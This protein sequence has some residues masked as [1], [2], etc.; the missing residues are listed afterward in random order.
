[1]YRRFARSPSNGMTVL[2]FLDFLKASQTELDEDGARNHYFEC[3]KYPEDED[4]AAEVAS[5]TAT[6]G[7]FASAVVRISNA[8]TM[9]EFGESEKGLHEQLVDWLQKFGANVG[10]KKPD[11]EQNTLTY[12]SS[13]RDP[14]FFDPPTEF[15][16]T[17]PKV[18]LLLA[19]GEQEGKVVIELNATASPKCA[20]NF[21]CL[22]TGE[23]GN[24]ELT[25]LP[26][27]LKGNEF[28]RLVK[29]MCLQGG[30]IEGGD[31]YGGESVY[32]GEF[33]DEPFTISHNAAGIVSMGNSGPNTNT[34]QF[35]ITLGACPH[36]DQENNAFGNV[37]E[38]MEYVTQIGELECDEDDKP[39][40]SVLIKDCGVY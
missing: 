7:Q 38:G 6:V 35:F 33:E 1:M 13:K 3:T 20:W 34:S 19:W 15:V 30:D 2:E 23:K 31:G 24:G 17:S 9:Q 21:Q 12:Q 10:E 27:T 39:V 22:C 25:N 8:Y 18:F 40:V 4:D 32:G 28:H 14:S 37:V 36:L 26:L 11:R 16:G 29:D 5:I